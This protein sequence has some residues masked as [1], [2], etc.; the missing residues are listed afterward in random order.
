MGHQKR[1]LPFLLYR[2]FIFSTFMLFGY[3]GNAQMRMDTLLNSLEHLKGEERLSTL[4]NIIW[5][6]GFSQPELAEFYSREAFSLAD[7]LKNPKKKIDAQN[8]LAIAYITAQDYEKALAQLKAAK[9]LSVEIDYKKG[10]G[11]AYNNFG[12]YYYTIEDYPLAYE[13]FLK[14]LKVREKFGDLP[15][16]AASYNNM[17]L[18]AL[19]QGSYTEAQEL[20]DKSYRTYKDAG[21]PLRAASILNNLGNMYGRTNDHKKALDA[22]LIAEAIFDSLHMEHQAATARNNIASAKINLGNFDGALEYGQ[23]ALE[24]RRRTNN[25]DALID[26]LSNM[27][28]LMI[29]KGDY[30]KAVE[31]LTE[32]ESILTERGNQ[33]QSQKI[34]QFL[35]EAY[36]GIGDFRKALKSTQLALALKDSVFTADKSKAVEEMKNKYELEKY[37][38]ELDEA[39]NQ[40]IL[41]EVSFKRLSKVSIGIGILLLLSL[42]LAY[43]LYRSQKLNKAINIQL[44]NS[45]KIIAD[46]NHSLLEL[47]KEKDYFLSIVAHDIANQL[48]NIQGLLTLI[49]HNQETLSED[50]NS[51]IHRARSITGNLVLMVRKVL[52]IR[53]LEQAELIPDLKSFEI[54]EILD[55]IFESYGEVSRLKDISLNI[56]DEGKEHTILAD[57]QFTSQVVDNLISNAIKF[58]SP[59]SAVDVYLKNEAEEVIISIADR[60]PGIP[61]S[62]WD[63]MFGKFQRLTPR[64]TAGETSTGLGLSIIKRYMDAMKGKVWYEDRPGGGSIFNISFRKGQ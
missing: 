57:F 27:G 1:G 12:R 52:D 59:S 14:S 5:L 60:G 6:Y 3:L 8:Y 61:A 64:P 32:A 11:D 56:H 26:I 40:S 48:A 36:E 23:R 49:G 58:S 31:Y 28:N 30:K 33:N 19:L 35:G 7:E 17:A 37:K 10:L 22:Y 45:N 34:H 13:Y 16:M 42:I 63:K 46:Q 21:D 2:L 55:S 41:N 53:N 18:I 47:N 50:Q 39:I 20:F 15:G 4:N 43:N 38:A 44:S 62:D 51:Y 9:A 25:R 54:K 29:K 24:Y